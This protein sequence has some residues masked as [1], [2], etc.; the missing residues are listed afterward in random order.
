[1]V[2]LC[3][4]A[5]ILLG[6]AVSA[7]APYRDYV[8]GPEDTITIHVVDV[9]FTDQNPL[10][11]ETSGHVKLPLVG[12]MMAGGLTPAQLED[13]LAESLKMYVRNPQV[14][15]RL[16]E[17]RSQPVTV[18]G[19]VTTPGI[20]QLRGR[21][22]LLEIISLA[23]GLRQDA[24]TIATVTRAKAFGPIPLPQAKTDASGEYMSCAIN[25]RELMEART[26]ANNILIQPTDVIA[27][28]KAPVV[29]V[30]GAVKK[31]GGF[32][33]SAQEKVSVLQALAMAEG[34][35]RTSAPSRARVLRKTNDP[36]KRQEMAI[37]LKKILEGK[38]ADLAL[39]TDDIL[40]I[41]TSTAKNAGL[42]TLETAINIGTGV[43]IFRR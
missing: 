36:E 11:I 24:G 9:P 12:R 41:P 23:G 21:K 42:K 28:E 30:I 18:V 33:L 5:F 6:A 31:S 16:V 35:E 25:L 14:L 10:R 29:Y 22:T 20:Q 26:P 15:V 40:F 2:R 4:A 39:Q 17:F 32:V 3:L 7:Q 43:L 13:R 19:A 1:M 27:V 37:D 8:L 38:Q 34:L